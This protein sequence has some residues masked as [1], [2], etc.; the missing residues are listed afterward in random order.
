M[1]GQ[2]WAVE[3]PVEPFQVGM[4]AIGGETTGSA[5]PGRYGQVFSVRLFGG[6]G[7][8]GVD[9]VSFRCGRLLECPPGLLG[10]P[11]LLI[12]I[13]AWSLVYGC[14]GGVFRGAVAGRDR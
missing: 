4:L 6:P 10:A 12:E 11:W 9:Q 1:Q 8:P 3:P 13:C 5:A 2:D 7:R 14:V